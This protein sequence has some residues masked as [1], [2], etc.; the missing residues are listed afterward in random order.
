MS[1]VAVFQPQANQH[2]QRTHENNRYGP[3]QI[4]G[5]MPIRCADRKER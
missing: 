5:K 1:D 4:V 2:G 3:A